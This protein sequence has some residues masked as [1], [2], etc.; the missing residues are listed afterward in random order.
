MESSM[1]K[2]GL[3][4]PHRNEDGEISHKHGNIATGWV[5][6]LRRETFADLGITER[7]CPLYPQ[8]RKRL[9]PSGTSALCQDRIWA[10][11][12]A[13]FVGA[14]EQCRRNGDCRPAA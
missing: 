6:T 5:A 12:F 3:D 2:A 9:P 10:L 7:Q 11:L 13:Y 14:D 4:N 1:S 8:L